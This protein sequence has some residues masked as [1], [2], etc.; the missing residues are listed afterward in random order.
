MVEVADKK[1]KP[2][3]RKRRAILVVLAV[4]LV[5]GGVWYFTAGRSRGPVKVDMALDLGG[6]VAL[7]LVLIPAGKF[8]M[9]SPAGEPGRGGEEGPRHEVTITR[10]FYMGSYSVTQ[11][12]YERVMGSNPS[13]YK[14]VTNPV[15]MVSWDDAVEFCKKLS[16]KTGKKVR[17]PTEAEWEYACRAGTTSAFNTGD[18]LNPGQADCNFSVSSPNPGYL[19]KFMAWLRSFLPAGEQ[20]KGGPKPVGSFGPN[21]WGLYDMHG[22]VWQWCAD[23]YGEDYYAN[24]PASD[25][26]GPETGAGRVQRGGGW[27]NLPANCRSAVRNRSAPDYRFNGRGFRVAVDSE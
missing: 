4:C 5:A 19:A 25:P 20:A 12:Q 18:T 22:N 24:S 15:E 11:G 9:G 14:G 27:N 6:G 1:P 13:Y 17:L 10:P 21:A 16:R 3:S 7:K 8:M 23:R 2:L 26:A